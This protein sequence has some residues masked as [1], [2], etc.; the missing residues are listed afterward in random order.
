LISAHDPAGLYTPAQSPE[1]GDHIASTARTDAL[2]RDPYHWYWCLWGDT[3][4]LPPDVAI[5]H[6]VADDQYSDPRETS[7]HHGQME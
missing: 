4:Y 7:G 2:A 3:F 5:K 6:Q 1:V